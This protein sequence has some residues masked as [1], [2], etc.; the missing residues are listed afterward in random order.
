MQHPYLHIVLSCHQHITYITRVLFLACNRRKCSNCNRRVMFVSTSSMTFQFHRYSLESLA[1][2]SKFSAKNNVN[3][4]PYFLQMF[5]N[6]SPVRN[7]C[8]FYSIRLKGFSTL[9]RICQADDKY[10]ILVA[11]QTHESFH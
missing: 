10:Q 2:L 7:F 6:T 9:S 4:R 5:L 11:F 1:S 8:F 3:V